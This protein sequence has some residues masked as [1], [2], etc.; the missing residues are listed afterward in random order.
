MMYQKPGREEHLAQAYR[1]IG[2]VPELLEYVQKVVT[3]NSEKTA[4]E[5]VDAGELNRDGDEATPG[6]VHVPALE[7]RVCR[8]L[9]AEQLDQGDFGW[10]SFFALAV[11]TSGAL[12][13]K[14][15][16]FVEPQLCWTA[17][18]AMTYLAR[19]PGQMTLH[20]MQILLRSKNLTG[21][22]R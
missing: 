15:K 3:E 1:Q 4:G 6:S 9:P 17:G 7:R 16:L 22:M 2:C 5:K 8:N 11:T 18:L 14:Y 19:V 12:L 13:A 21:S 20:A 10:C